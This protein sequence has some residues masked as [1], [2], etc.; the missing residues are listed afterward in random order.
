MA[1]AVL[2][3]GAALTATA[4]GKLTVSSKKPSVDGVIKAGE[5]TF[6]QDFDQQMTVYASRTGATLYLAV[7]GN[8]GGW[9]A[10][11]I[12]QKMD[13]ADIFMGFVKGGKA[14]FKPQLGS[15]HRH[16]DAPAD[17]AATVESYALKER[18]G[19]TTLEVALKAGAYLKD[20]QPALDVI[21]A[22]GDQGNFTQYHSYRNL[23][24]I[25]LK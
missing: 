6:S 21:F 13:G 1:I 2:L 23:A 24:S 10:I 15:G 17:V 8:T 14:T 20:G 9:V 5:Y 11:G 18:G 19:K 22:M 7:V 16:G 12:G 25:P 4:Q 3:A